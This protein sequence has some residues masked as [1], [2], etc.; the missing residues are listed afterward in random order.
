[1][2]SLFEKKVKYLIEYTLKYFFLMKKDIFNYFMKLILENCIHSDIQIKIASLRC[3]IDFSKPNILKLPEI[4]ESMLQILTNLILDKDTEVAIPAIELF[5]TIAEEEK[6]NFAV[7]NIQNFQMTAKISPA[8]INL[9]LQNLMKGSKGEDDNDDEGEGGLT[10][11]DTSYRCLCSIVEL[12]GDSC[13]ETIAVFVSSK[14]I[15]FIN[16]FLK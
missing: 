11:R 1:M 8:L 3:L 2:E 15:I 9:L 12:L 14:F 4:I 10:I 7:K 16:I 6:D 5:N 13:I